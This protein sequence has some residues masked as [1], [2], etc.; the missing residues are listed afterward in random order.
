MVIVVMGVTGAGKTT[1]GRKLALR[2]GGSFYDADD[3]H[4]PANRQK[5]G[6]GIPLSD[7][8]RRPWLEI[9]HGQMQKWSKEKATA[10]LACSALKQSYRD[11]LSAGLD[12]KW[13]YLKGDRETIRQRIEKRQGH[14]AGSPL[15]D[16]QFEALEEPR[17]AVVV[18]LREEPD[19]I[20]D[21]ILKA[22]KG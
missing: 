2:L 20:A 13:V 21:R 9:L 1:V 11:L 8:D 10:V 12:V 5:M 4:S 19:R 18:D 22:L 16:S 14:F 3:F 17:D 7:E 15:L 6:Q